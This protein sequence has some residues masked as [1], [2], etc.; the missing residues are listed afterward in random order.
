MAHAQ[1]NLK[2][3]YIVK[4]SG[5]TLRGYIDYR[6]RGENPEQVRFTNLWMKKHYHLVLRIVRPLVLMVL[7]VM[8]A[9]W[10]Q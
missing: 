6:E 5:D 7:L 2:K 8:K 1:I 4:Q 3:G 9:M 10:C